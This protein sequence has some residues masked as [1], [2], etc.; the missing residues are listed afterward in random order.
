M[1]EGLKERLRDV[2]V[3]I[4]TGV[5]TA[6]SASVADALNRSGYTSS[7]YTPE[8]LLTSAR[9]EIEMVYKFVLVGAIAATLETLLLWSF[10]EIAGFNYL[11]VAAFSIEFAI[12]LQY[13]INNLWTFGHK[14]HDHARGMLGGLVRT[15]LVRGTSIPLQVSILYVFV[16][17]GGIYF[18]FANV[19]AMVISG[20]YRYILDSRWTWSTDR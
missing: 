10:V 13:F 9:N 16:N 20:V 11:V 12:I 15:N 3:S 2:N 1:F 19:G 5:A 4:N 6:I 7:G 17:F 8:E 14:K 18:V